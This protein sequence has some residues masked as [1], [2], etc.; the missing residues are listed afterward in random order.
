[1]SADL[2]IEPLIED[3]FQTVAAFEQ[4]L[5]SQP[6][7]AEKQFEFVN[8]KII[9]KPVMKQEELFIV[10]F[11]LDLFQTTK[12]GKNKIGR[13]IPELDSH[14]DKQ[15]KRIPDISYYTNE[16]IKEMRKGKRFSTPFPIEILSP[17][18]LLRDVE[19][20]IQDYFDAN[21]QVVWYISPEQ[22]QIYV[23]HSPTDVTIRKGKDV[24]SAAPI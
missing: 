22:Q 13:L 23:Y 6:H 10:T 4:W 24:C 3:K 5:S 1:M 8:G 9:E 15:R 17:Y 18:D 20:K 19:D 12:T 14:I 11:L 21:V 2:I 7:L 16:Q